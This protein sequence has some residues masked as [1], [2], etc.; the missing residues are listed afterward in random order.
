[1]SYSYTESAT[2]SFTLT[3]ARHL[4]SKVAT[5]LKRIQRFYGS[6]SDEWIAAFEAE[7]IQ[8]L[9]AGYLREVTYGFRRGGQWIEPTLRYSAQELGEG[10]LDD[11]P[12][13]VRPNANVSGAAFH[14]YLTQNAAWNGLSSEQQATFKGTLPFQR[15]GA[16]EPT[17]NGYL[18]SDRTYSAGGRSLTRSSVRSS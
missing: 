5:D 1:M 7:I 10:T 13:R 17:V 3:H 15:G 18:Q 4:A 6:P 16:P 11:D 12:G 8:Y 2:V 9:K 14:S